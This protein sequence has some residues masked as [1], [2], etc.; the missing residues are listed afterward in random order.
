M[1]TPTTGRLLR[2]FVG[3]SDR[4]RGK[5]LY[6]AIVERARETGLA[7]ATVFRGVMGFGKNSR[8]HSAHILTLSTDLSMVIEIVDSE[9]KIAAFLPCLDEMVE[10]GL[11]TTESVEVIRYA[12]GGSE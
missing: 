9:E 12:A 1:K 4:W 8:I 7:G 11:V 10:E 2:A 6:E 3:E 5:P